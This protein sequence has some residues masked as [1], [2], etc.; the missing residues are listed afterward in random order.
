MHYAKLPTDYQLIDFAANNNLSLKTCGSDPGAPGSVPRYYSL[1]ESAPP[2]FLHARA[3]CQTVL[4]S[5]SNSGTENSRCCSSDA[6]SVVSSFS[7]ECNDICCAR[8]SPAILRRR[9][10]RLSA[11]ATNASCS[12]CLTSLADRRQLCALRRCKGRVKWER[13]D[14]VQE[15]VLISSSI[16]PHYQ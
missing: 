3:A 10:G 8:S 6:I 15:E 4:A 11:R 13:G 14:P 7:R 1:C 9:P 5:A 2:P 12:L 16:Q